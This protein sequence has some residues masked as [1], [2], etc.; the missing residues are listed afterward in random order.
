[1]Y[2]VGQ[3][4]C[5]LDFVT[6]DLQSHIHLIPVH[7][8]SRT[9]D[10]IKWTN[11]VYWVG[12][13]KSSVWH[14][15]YTWFFSRTLDLSSVAVGFNRWDVLE[16]LGKFNYRLIEVAQSLEPVRHL[17]V[18]VRENGTG[19]QIINGLCLSSCDVDICFMRTGLNTWGKWCCFCYGIIS[20]MWT[21]RPSSRRNTDTT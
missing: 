11:R 13:K 20:C 6:L 4:K 21:R 7:L 12:Q 8:I 5:T 9:L 17:P 1:M 10:L 18:V 3:I 15:L 14:T 2:L 16:R 19:H